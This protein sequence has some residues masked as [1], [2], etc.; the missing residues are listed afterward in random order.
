MTIDEALKHFVSGYELCKKLEIKS[1]N[2]YK[3]KSAGWI[4]LKQQHRI[5]ELVGG[6][7]PIDID[8]DA[9]SIRL[10]KGQ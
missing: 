1:Q 2:F 10:E 8:K 4:P 3:W 9:L 7:L 5:N 6:V